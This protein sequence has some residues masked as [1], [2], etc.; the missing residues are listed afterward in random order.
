MISVQ[1]I[2][3]NSAETSPTPPRIMGLSQQRLATLLLF[4]APL[5]FSSNMLVAKVTA[6]L[7]PPVALAFWRWVLTFGLLACFVGPRLWARR[8]DIAREWKDLLI[9]GGLG[10][11][12]SG[13]FVYIAADTTS[14]TNIGLIYT[15]APVLIIL[16]AGLLYRE[17]LSRLQ[18]L[19]VVASLGGVLWIIAKGAP[20]SLLTLDFVAGDL[21]VVGATIGWALYSV[22]QRHRPSAMGLMTRLAATVGGGCLVLLPFTIWEGVTQGLPVITG[23]S[24]AAIAFLAIFASFIAYQIYAFI[25]RVLGAGRTSLLMYLIPV[26][27]SA[28]AWALLGETLATYHVVGAALVLPG[29]YLAT[30]A[31]RAN[32]K[33]METG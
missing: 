33:A 30:R 15:A 19:G 32:P 17:P 11:G 12:V 22:L 23:E 29:I 9:L 31:P 13:A 27:N 25:Q 2:M 28:L 16:L 6:D 20:A 14:A 7:I 18:A 24:L 1:A 3:E 8:A 21:W 10:M 5:L 4:V 26:Y